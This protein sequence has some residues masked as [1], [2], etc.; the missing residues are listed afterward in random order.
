MKIE[1]VRA[2][3]AGLMGSGIAQVCAQAGLDVT[4]NALLNRYEEIRDPRWYPPMILRR[5]VRAGHLGRKTGR[6]GYTY[7]EDG[8]RIRE[9]T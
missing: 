6:G 5:K 8:N 2:V 7:D 4:C 3:G 9:E 1:R